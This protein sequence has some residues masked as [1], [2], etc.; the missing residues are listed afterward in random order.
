MAEEQMEGTVSYRSKLLNLDMAGQSSLSQKEVV[1]AD[2]DFHI[3]REGAIL[4]IEFSAVVRE[5]LSKGME[6]TL[7]VKLL[8]RY[9]SYHDLK[10]RTEAL[11]KLKGSFQ[12]VDLEG[13]FY[14]ATFD[15]EEDYIKALTAGPW[16][17]FGAYL[18]VQPWTLDFDAS[19]YAVSKVVAWVRIPSLS[20]GYY[21]KSTLRAIGTL[22]GE[23]GVEY[24]GLPVICFECGKYGHSKERCKP[25]GQLSAA[26]LS[27][28]KNISISSTT[29]EG[30][31]HP[32]GSAV[33]E[34]SS[35]LPLSPYGLWMEVR[36]P[37][38]GNKQNWG[39]S[40]KMVG[41]YNNGGSR[42][43]V[44]FENEDLSASSTQINPMSNPMPA[45]SAPQ[46]QLTDDDRHEEA[47]RGSSGNQKP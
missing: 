6:R 29:G 42:Y 11:W 7:V 17:I 31:T 28:G 5:V 19:S 37:K 18:T 41:S 22:L 38:K 8:G 30:I 27:S 13:N 20:I 9:I 23:Y 16:M 26:D 40:P 15:L 12:L 24:E 43:N 3:S 4:S 1:L 10:A 25:G 39:K 35:D 47:A 36:Y 34:G 46:I 32:L 45:P 21:H 2:E 14:F 44:L 33:A